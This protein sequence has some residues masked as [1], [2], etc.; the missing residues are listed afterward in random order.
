[1]ILCC[2]L[3][4]LSTN[5]AFGQDIPIAR[6]FPLAL[7]NVWEYRVFHQQ[8]AEGQPE[9]SS[10]VLT[11]YL[12]TEVVEESDQ[13]GIHTLTLERISFSTGYVE[14]DR[15]SCK[16]EVGSDGSVIYSQ[17]EGQEGVCQRWDVLDY[18]FSIPL[19][20]GALEVSFNQT[21]SPNTVLIAGQEVKVESTGIRYS[22][23]AHGQWIL[24]FATGIG[25]YEW[26]DW[27]PPR[28]PDGYVISSSLEYASVNGVK[29]GANLA[30]HNQANPFEVVSTHSKEPLFPNPTRG[31]VHL[32]VPTTTQSLVRVDVLNT[33]GRDMNLEPIRNGSS[34]SN[35]TVDLSRMSSGV[36][37][38]RTVTN[39]SVTT[40]RVV[41]Y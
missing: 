37:F 40:Q 13:G 27:T 30:V 29:Y 39:T 28:N 33:L 38:I 8:W 14:T 7:G 17:T 21:Q 6:Y 18:Q 31:L 23:Q 19:A 3:I 11:G 35:Y 2:F 20:D 9:P 16:V 41:K 1:M 32:S 36:Y 4:A 34:Q 26:L 24:K 15:Y 10:K 25:L 5:V 12:T 22:S